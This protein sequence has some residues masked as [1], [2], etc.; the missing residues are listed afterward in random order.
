MIVRMIQTI[1]FGILVSSICFA[2]QNEITVGELIVHSEKKFSE[3]LEEQ[4][5]SIST[6]IM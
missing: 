4:I 5:I 3:L 6:P 2:E 1:I